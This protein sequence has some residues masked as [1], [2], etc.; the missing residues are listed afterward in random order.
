MDNRKNSHRGFTLVELVVI[1]IVLGI[2]AAAVIPRFVNLREE[3]EQAK[4][5]YVRGSFKAGVSLAH[6]KAMAQDLSKSSE[7]YYEVLGLLRV[8]SAHAGGNFT[9]TMNGV[10]VDMTP[11]GW[12]AIDQ[13]ASNCNVAKRPDNTPTRIATRKCLSSNPLLVLGVSRA[14]AGGGGGGGGGNGNGDGDG[15]DGDGD[16]GGGMPS[17]TVLEVVLQDIDLSGWT[18]QTNSSNRTVTFM[19]PSGESFRYNESNGNIQ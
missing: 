7:W 8:S 12:P 17:C 18:Q 19:A 3:A 11:E 9:I 16:G 5:E 10:P 14:H 2:L 13:T 15:D 6:G 1:L 4:L